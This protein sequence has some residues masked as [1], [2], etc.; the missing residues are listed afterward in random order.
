MK[1]FAFEWQSEA[2]SLALSRLLDP[3]V[4]KPQGKLAFHM[5]GSE[6]RV[7]LLDYTL[8]AEQSLGSFA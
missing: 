1:S 7:S 3:T 4:C 5:V 8:G 2:F 6:H